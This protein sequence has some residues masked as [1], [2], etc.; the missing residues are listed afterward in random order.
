MIPATAS[1]REKWEEGRGT[2]V[3]FNLDTVDCIYLCIYGIEALRKVI[4]DRGMRWLADSPILIYSNHL[5]L[6]YFIFVRTWVVLFD[7]CIENQNVWTKTIPNRYKPKDSSC[8]RKDFL[9]KEY[10]WFVRL[11]ITKEQL[12]FERRCNFSFWVIN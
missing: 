6:I 9:F 1:L 3:A 2:D 8:L 11:H 4:Y 10:L 5:R 7:C 12:I